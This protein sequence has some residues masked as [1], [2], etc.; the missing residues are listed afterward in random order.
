MLTNTVKRPQAK[1]ESL[2]RQEKEEIMI[3][4]DNPLRSVTFMSKSRFTRAWQCPK[5]LWYEINC[6][7]KKHIDTATQERMEMGHVIGEMAKQLFPGCVDVS[8]NEDGTLCTDK[9]LMIKRTVEAIASGVKYIAEASFGY[10]YHFCAVDILERTEDGWT[11]NE[12][13]SSKE[14]D[15]K[16]EKY[17]YGKDNIYL[18]D[19]TYQAAV[20]KA[21]N[22]NVTSY[23]LGLVS[24]DYKYM[25]GDLDL[26]QFF[27]FLDITDD[28]LANLPDVPKALDEIDR[29]ASSEEEP[30]IH[31]SRA[32]TC[33]YKCPYW[34]LC[35]ADLPEQS[36]FDLYRMSTQNKA[37]A[38][39]DGFI[40]FEDLWNGG[41]QFA[42]GRYGTIQKMQVEHA[43]YDL[44]DHIDREKIAK[45]VSNAKAK[46]A[47]LDFETLQTPIP[48]FANS[49]AY[50]QIPFQYSLHYDYGNGI[51]H[52]EF[53][54]DGH[55]DPRRAL[56]EQLV[57][58]IPDPD[59]TTVFAYN[60][61]FE[62]GRLK[63]LAAL[64]PDLHDHLMKIHAAMADLLD[65][66]NKGWYYNR[67]MGGSFSIKSVLPALF[68]DDPELNYKN[69][70]DVHNG[71][72][73]MQMYKKMATLEGTEY[74]RARDNLLKY[75]G[76]DT[77]AIVKVWERLKEVAAG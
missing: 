36:V 51:E 39:Y 77:W 64:Y 18:H 35:A 41:Y 69:L 50:A 58:D 63:E 2:A 9:S 54:G 12:M 45:F 28:V 1:R 34:H 7:E 17:P 16:K 76:L 6:P 56:A 48:I 14:K 66:F 67:A 65:P 25:G 43:L 11:L 68:P 60:M 21:C 38:Y 70:E 22:I 73:A 55:T 8:K 61:S 31:F 24:K 15:P 3:S 29:I 40:T 62:K 27:N 74:D 46:I 59:N 20:L 5:I 26:D 32:C 47:F 4:Q 42:S 44:S 30:D 75:C 57:A 71:T 53:L 37:D 33:P 23:K 52:A 19:V 72:E 10:G 13:K 49:Y